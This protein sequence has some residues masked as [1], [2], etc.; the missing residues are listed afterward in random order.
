MPKCNICGTEYP[1][2]HMSQH[3]AE[4][5]AETV[6]SLRA[7]VERLKRR[8]EGGLGEALELAVCS[9]ELLKADN[10]RLRGALQEIAD[11]LHAEPAVRAYEA[12]KK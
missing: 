10:E 5:L 6:A 12:L 4:T 2:R 9:A 3:C 11:S 8:T 1:T 7:E